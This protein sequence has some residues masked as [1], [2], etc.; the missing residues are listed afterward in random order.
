MSL[1]NE[2]I[3]M[4]SFEDR[5]I[6]ICL[7]T[8]LKEMTVANKHGSLTKNITNRIDEL[9]EWVHCN[10][11]NFSLLSAKWAL[12]DQNIEFECKRTELDK[13]TYDGKRAFILE[14]RNDD[15]VYLDG[16]PGHGSSISLSSIDL[17]EIYKKKKKD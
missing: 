14:L 17:K 4:L 10:G 6:L 7:L 1:K 8:A 2:G 5:S 16:V 3:S 15:T 12:E 11:G 13:T 9:I